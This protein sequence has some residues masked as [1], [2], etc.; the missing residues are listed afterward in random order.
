MLLHR[1]AES[2]VRKIVGN[3]L[4]NV[5]TPDRARSPVGFY[6]TEQEQFQQK[7]PDVNFIFLFLEKEI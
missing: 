2:I 6:S 3:I 1:E 5:R 7:N 4:D